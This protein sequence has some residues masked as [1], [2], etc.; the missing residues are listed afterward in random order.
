M[1]V[2]S[3]SFEIVENGDFKDIRIT[4]KYGAR[5]RAREIISGLKRVSKPGLRVYAGKDESS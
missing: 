1:K 4:L 2:I 3:S 5:T